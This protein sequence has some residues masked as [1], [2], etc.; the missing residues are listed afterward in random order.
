MVELGGLG[1]WGP[2]GRRCSLISAPTS[3]ELIALPT[4][5]A[6]V[7][8]RDLW[9]G[10][11]SVATDLKKHHGAARGAAPGRPADVLTMEEVPRHPHNI[12]RG[13]SVTIGGIRQ[14]ASAPAFSDTPSDSP[15]GW[16]VASW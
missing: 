14:P 5:G 4:R 13:T 2:F 11:G 7:I 16:A 1:P 8:D 12:D 3:S 6:P 9:R 10:R 15:N